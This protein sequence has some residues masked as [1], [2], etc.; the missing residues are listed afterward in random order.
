MPAPVTCQVA[1]TAGIGG[2]VTVNGAGS[3][4]VNENDT[5]NV[6]ITPEAEYQV[7][8]ITVNNQAYPYS[9]NSFTLTISTDTTI[10]VAFIKKSDVAGIGGNSGI[11]G[12][13][14]FYQKDYQ[15]EGGD[16]AYTAVTVYYKVSVPEGWDVSKCGLK[17]TA[18]DGTTV[19]LS[20]AD[21]S[22]DGKFGIRFFGDGIQTGETYSGRAYV[23]YEQD[24]TEYEQEE[25]DT[26]RIEEEQ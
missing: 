6:L 26:Y 20:A 19:D 8:T 25:E 11:T 13:Y 10:S 16:K 17:L 9:G 4:T 2:T 24:E 21:W 12:G 3:V 14:V 1:A 15:P 5:V 23:Q 22:S 18:P 7:D